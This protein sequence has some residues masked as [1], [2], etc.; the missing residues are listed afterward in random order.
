MYLAEGRDKRV[1]AILEV[2]EWAGT[3]KLVVIGSSGVG[4]TALLRLYC[5]H[6]WDPRLATS[7]IGIDFKTKRLLVGDQ[8]YKVN[9]FDTAGQERFRTLSASYYRGAHGVILVYDITNRKSFLDLEGWFQEA[10]TCSTEVVVLCLVGAKLDKAAQGERQVSTEEGRALAESHGAIFYEVS[11]KTGEN[12]REPFVG[13]VQRI[14]GTPGLLEAVRRK[15]VPDAL[16]LNRGDYYTK[17]IILVSLL[18]CCL[19]G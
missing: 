17:P 13:T 14:V 5:D 16:R 6:E 12:F 10:K 15:P 2:G 4:K 1:K 19:S 3:V 7:T 8:P 18:H 9:I 11:A